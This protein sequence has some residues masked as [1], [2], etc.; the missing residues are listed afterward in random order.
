[1]S[2]ATREQKAVVTDFA[3]AGAFRSF[4]RQKNMKERLEENTSERLR[5]RT[6]TEY[7]GKQKRNPQ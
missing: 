5:L 1:M 6:A 4:G 3:S 7:N 2:L